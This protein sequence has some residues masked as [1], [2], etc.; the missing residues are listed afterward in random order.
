MIDVGKNVFEFEAIVLLVWKLE[1]DC[2]RVAIRFQF[3]SLIG[4]CH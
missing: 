3:S 1:D 4:Y 2:R